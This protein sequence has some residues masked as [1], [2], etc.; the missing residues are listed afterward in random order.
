MSRSYTSSPPKRLRGVQWNSFSF[1]EYTLTKIQIEGFDMFLQ[2]CGSK[3]KRQKGL[4]LAATQH[5]KHK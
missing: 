4:K 5:K 1:L 2:Q 3:K